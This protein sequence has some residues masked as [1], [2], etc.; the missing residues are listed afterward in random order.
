M[1]FDGFLYTVTAKVLFTKEE[2]DIMIRL[3]LDHYDNTCQAAAK[4]RNDNDIR[5][6]G[7]LVIWKWDYEDEN[8]GPTP[9][10]VTPQQLGL[11]LKILE[12]RA[13]LKEE[14]LFDKASGLSDTIRN[15]LRNISARWKELNEPETVQEHLDAGIPVMTAQQKP[16]THDT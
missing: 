10:E 7:M 3:A 16:R 6:T 4:P 5:S 14:D 1:R 13:F 2:L 15:L 8:C 12:G 11:L 9:R